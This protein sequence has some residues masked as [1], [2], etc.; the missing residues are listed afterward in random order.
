MKK[1]QAPIPLE[2]CPFCGGEARLVTLWVYIKKGGA[3]GIARLD[4][5]E[6]YR[7]VR[8]EVCEAGTKALPLLESVLA[9]NK[10]TGDN[11]DK[12]LDRQ[13]CDGNY[14]R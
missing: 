4:G 10:R 9:W 6:P 12:R 14:R 8:C 13:N 3:T 5:E 11:I 1:K 2:A 7:R